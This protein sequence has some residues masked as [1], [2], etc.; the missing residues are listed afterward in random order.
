M[1]SNASSKIA[2]DATNAGL[3]DLGD[4]FEQP[5]RDLCRGIVGIDQDSEPR[6]AGF[7]AALPSPNQRPGI[8][9]L[10]DRYAIGE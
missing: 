6:R 5:V 9:H 7:L 2:V 3:T 4:L 8:S 1:S 10:C